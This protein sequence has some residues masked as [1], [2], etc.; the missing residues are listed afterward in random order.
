MK[1]INI[2]VVTMA[3]LAIGLA[4]GFTFAQTNNTFNGNM[5]LQQKTQL[6][7]AG[8]TGCGNSQ[9]M[10]QLMKEN[11]F[12]EIANYTEAGNY[13]EMN[14]WMKNL[15]DEDYDKMLDI[16]QENGYGN[17]ASMMESMGKENMQK[18]HNS[19]MGNNGMM[20]MMGRI[21]K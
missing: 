18:M 12:A 17:M 8:D 2:I 5:M 10:I 9:E 21:N 3:V 19:M 20:N 4:S 1:R 13:E 7:Q 6:N 14:E 11:G 16:M 15:T